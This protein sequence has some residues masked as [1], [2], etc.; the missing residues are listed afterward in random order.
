MNV[1]LTV[2]GVS[3]GVDVVRVAVLVSDEVVSV[4]LVVEVVVVGA[5]F[6][7]GVDVGGVLLCGSEVISVGLGEV[8]FS[9]CEGAVV[10]E[11]PPFPRH[12][13]EKTTIPA[14]AKARS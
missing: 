11:E 10:A 13:A 8:V 7:G 12:P 5:E 2:P 1:T 14:S 3:V 9:D 4:A 6:V